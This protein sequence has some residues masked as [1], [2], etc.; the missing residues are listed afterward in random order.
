MSGSLVDVYQVTVWCLSC[1]SYHDAS[2]YVRISITSL[3]GMMVERWWCVIL[4]ALAGAFGCSL[5][6]RVSALRNVAETPC[7]RT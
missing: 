5:D 6:L 7:L 1:V 4:R 3:Y 2:A